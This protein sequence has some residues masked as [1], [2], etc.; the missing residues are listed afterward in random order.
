MLTRG[1]HNSNSQP[2]YRLITGKKKSKPKRVTPRDEHDGKP[3]F[4]TTYDPSMK[5][6]KNVKVTEVTTHSTDREIE[7][8]GLSGGLEHE[9]IEIHKTK[10][11]FQLEDKPSHVET[12]PR[13][14][15]HRKKY[16]TE[17]VEGE[18]SSE[19]RQDHSL[20]HRFDHESPV[21]TL[22]PYSSY[23][24]TTIVKEG[25]ST[26]AVYS[27]STPGVPS[28]GKW[29]TSD[30]RA[31]RDH[32][33]TFEEK[34]SEEVSLSDYV[35][36]NTRAKSQVLERQE[37]KLSSTEH[38]RVGYTAKETTPAVDT[39]KLSS[40]DTSVP[41]V[42]TI[43]SPKQSIRYYRDVTSREPDQITQLDQDQREDEEEQEER[44]HNRK[45]ET[46]R[47]EK[48]R[49]RELE[50]VQE[51]ERHQEEVES[52]HLP[53][54]EPVP[55]TSRV[56]PKA[57]LDVH[58]R[59]P[60]PIEPQTVEETRPASLPEIGITR[61]SESLGIPSENREET[62]E[63]P[64]NSGASTSIHEEESEKN[65][66]ECDSRTDRTIKRSGSIRSRSDV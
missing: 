62:T 23:G 57:R 10:E 38:P 24:S 12:P 27:E 28:A 36:P 33:Y 55:K 19:R 29:Q 37:A 49:Q 51:I 53:T 56:H 39:A 66:N 60:E 34:P 54:D 30:Q 63:V 7:T 48:E 43:V 58:R 52:G 15:E 22:K 13:V 31:R 3:R 65:Q 32:G 41:S 8:E 6:L 17:E 26:R 44:L 16:E 61:D 21:N 11:E 64:T 50:R 46:E 35:Q 14:T 18:R 59:K 4:N 47:K 2:W 42:A 5:T 45:K 40:F 1:E 25:P 9:S 20:R